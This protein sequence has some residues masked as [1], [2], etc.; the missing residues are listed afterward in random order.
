MGLVAVSEVEGSAEVAAEVVL[1]LDA[2]EDVLVD[3]LLVAGT[4][5]GNLLLL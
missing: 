1:L 5:A 4:S 2:G 3:G